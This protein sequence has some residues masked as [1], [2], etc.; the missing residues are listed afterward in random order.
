M[1]EDLL[2]KFNETF[3]NLIEDLATAL[4]GDDELDAYKLI[5]QGFVY[6]NRGGVLRI[7]HK[8]VTLRFE[9]EIMNRDASFFL[10]HEFVNV[11]PKVSQIIMKLKGCWHLLN[12]ENRGVVWRYFRVLIMLDKK[13]LKDMTVS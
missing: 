10:S 9:K 13:I 8:H 4:G 11:T 2:D 1:D 12:E 5:V 7:F 3:I 6:A